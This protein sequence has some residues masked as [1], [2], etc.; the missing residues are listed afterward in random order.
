MECSGS[1]LQCAQCVVKAHVNHPL[2]RLEVSFQS[3]FVSFHDD[4]LCPKQ[5]DCVSGFFHCKMLYGFGLV[6]RLG[7]HGRPCPVPCTLAKPFIVIDMNGVHQLRL[8]YCGCSRAQEN[9]RQILCHAWYPAS[10]DQPKMAFTFDVLDTYHK[11][12]LQG[13]LNLYDFYHAILQKTDNCGRLKWLV[14]Q[15]IS[16]IIAHTHSGPASVP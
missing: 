5:W 12:T 2:H 7:H 9:F 14:S 16:T 15:F 6:I 11:L 3:L 13:K 4:N 8:E 1:A 10:S